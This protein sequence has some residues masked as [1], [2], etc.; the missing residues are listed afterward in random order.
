MIERAQSEVA[1]IVGDDDE[2][3]ELLPQLQEARARGVT[4]VVISPVPYDAG[5]V[6]IVVYPHGQS[7]RQATGHGLALIV[8]GSESLIGEVDRSESAAWTTNGFAVA[9]ALWCLKC[10]MAGLSKSR[11]LRASRPKRKSAR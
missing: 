3:D 4:L 9:L 1:L 11:A 8:D 7:L 6:P 5:D 10:E 2:L